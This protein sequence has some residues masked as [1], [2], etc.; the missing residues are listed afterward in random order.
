M[1]QMKCRYQGKL[2]GATMNFFKLGIALYLILLFAYTGFSKLIDTKALFT[3]L[4]NA[5]LFFTE[6]TADIL[7]WLI[8][9]GEI[10]I[11]GAIIFEDFR[12]IGLLSSLILLS[13]FTAYSIWI[14]FISPYEPCTCGGIL[15][16]LSLKQHLLLNTISL[17]LATTGLYFEKN[18]KL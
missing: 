15:S 3:T 12:K 13:L 2:N 16:L 1:N 6:H 10:G 18:E 17:V 7:S 11:A 4:R 5:P 8:P 9:L 14:V